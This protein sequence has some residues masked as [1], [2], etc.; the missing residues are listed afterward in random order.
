MALPS[1]F[2]VIINFLQ[3]IMK[4]IDKKLDKNIER[5]QN[6]II[7]CKD[8]SR[9]VS[10]REEISTVKRKAYLDENYWAKAVPSFGSNTPKI[11]VVGLAPGAHGANRTGRVFTGDSSGEWLYRSLFRNGLA[12][13]PTSDGPD[14]GQELFD[15]RITCI[16]KCVPPENK[17]TPGEIKNCARWLGDE[18][19]IFYPTVKA[20][21]ALGALAWGQ[22]VKSL[23][24]E[25]EFKS[26][27]KFSHGSEIRWRGEDG[28]NRILLGSY[29]PSQQNTFTG[30]L[31]EAMLDQ[32]F[33]KAGRFAR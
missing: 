30:R 5:L 15:L 25:P 27:V 31:T 14:D 9:L 26:S 11:L 32:V 4:D 23:S 16:V 28:N 8:C 22:I 1:H 19:E 33:E 18:L 29:H 12:K 6:K 13:I 24:F 7:N 10:W 21:V 17:P 2:R 20:I 3:I